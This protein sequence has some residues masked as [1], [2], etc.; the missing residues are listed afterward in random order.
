MGPTTWFVNSYSTAD[1]IRNIRPL[2]SAER[3]DGTEGAQQLRIARRLDVPDV[4]AGEVD[5]VPAEWGTDQGRG[6]K[7]TSGV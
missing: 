4:V 5:V 1:Q 7:W 3:L 6:M 2:C